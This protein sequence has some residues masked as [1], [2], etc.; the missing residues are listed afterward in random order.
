MSLLFSM[1]NLNTK[2][3]K[4]INFCQGFFIFI[5]YVIG[6]SEVRSAFKRLQEKHSLSRSVGERSYALRSISKVTFSVLLL[7]IYMTDCNDR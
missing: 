2:P 1:F 5:V 7:Y 3:E 4:V 6:N